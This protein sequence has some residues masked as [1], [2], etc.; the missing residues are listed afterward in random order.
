MSIYEFKAKTISGED[1]SLKTHEGKVIIIVNTASK[2]G[3]TPQYEGLE[4]LYQTYKDKDL[5]ILGFPCNQFGHQEPGNHDEI[6][7]FCTL[8]YG[9]SFPIMEK[10]D[11]NGDHAHP[12]FDYL[13]K[14]APGTLGKSIKWNFTKFLIDRKGNV[15]NRYAPTTSPDKMIKDIEK[16]L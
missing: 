15:I 4:W 11:V 7:S 16:L 14:Q 1:I 3:L 10:V 5:V 13:K 9:V 6:S 2:C 8:N 12:L